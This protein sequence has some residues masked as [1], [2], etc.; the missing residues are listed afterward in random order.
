MNGVALAYRTV[1]NGLHNGGCRCKKRRATSQEMGNAAV[2]FTLRR[3]VAF[4]EAAGNAV[5]KEGLAC[6]GAANS[7]NPLDS[8]CKCPP[9]VDE[10]HLGDN[11][12][13]GNLWSY[14]LDEPHIYGALFGMVTRRREVSEA[15]TTTGHDSTDDME[16]GIRHLLRFGKCLV[17]PI[18]LVN[19]RKMHGG[20]GRVN[21]SDNQQ[22]QHRLE[23]F[24]RLFPALAYT[25]RPQ[26]RPVVLKRHAFTWLRYAQ[27]KSWCKAAAA[28]FKEE[29][30]HAES[31]KR[32]RIA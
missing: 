4:L 24:R 14:V 8:T 16:R 11:R 9:Y 6:W 5:R 1:N 21:M 27:N 31:T 12:H 22:A 28:L 20:V 19:K 2:E 29:T 18:V 10:N 7:A 32:Q 26:S 30:G 3:W 17:F 25:G 23:V 13:E 15:L